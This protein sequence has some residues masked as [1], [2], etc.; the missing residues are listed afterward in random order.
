MFFVFK[1]LGATR[2]SILSR[3]NVIWRFLGGGGGVKKMNDSG[4]V[5]KLTFSLLK[6]S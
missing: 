6:E 4:V 3:S 2:K 1:N 5:V